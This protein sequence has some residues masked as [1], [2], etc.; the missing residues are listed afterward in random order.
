[1]SKH[2]SRR[3]FLQTA[4]TAPLAAAAGSAARL[5]AVHI[6]RR[7]NFIRDLPTP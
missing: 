6:A 3:S 7:H 1:M 5:D 4:A 2:P